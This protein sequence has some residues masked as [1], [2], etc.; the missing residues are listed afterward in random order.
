MIEEHQPQQT[1]IMPK[2]TY[3]LKNLWNGLHQSLFKQTNIENYLWMASLPFPMHYAKYDLCGL[4]SQPSFTWINARILG[5][6]KVTGLVALPSSCGCGWCFGSIGPK[7]LFP[8][9][10]QVINVVA[11]PGFV[12]LAYKM[13]YPCIFPNFFK[14]LM[15]T[16][17]ASLKG[18]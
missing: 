14:T 17:N 5:F 13:E 15:S 7:G 8:M 16:S 11:I 4:D 1:Q 10:H 18:V 2:L 3:L 12:V 9:G 6:S